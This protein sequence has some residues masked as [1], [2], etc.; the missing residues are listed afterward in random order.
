MFGFIASIGAGLLS[1]VH[2][3]QSKIIR[4]KIDTATT[5]LATAICFAVFSVI[6]LGV[7][8]LFGFRISVSNS[9]YLNAV[10]AAV[11]LTIASL[12]FLKGIKEVPL[13]RALPLLAIGPIIT[14]LLSGAANAT[15]MGGIIAVAI[16][17]FLFRTEPQK[18]GSRLLHRG[19]LYILITGILFGL[20]PIFDARAVAA[21]DPVFYSA[22]GGLLRLLFFALAFVALKQITPKTEGGSVR[23]LI[24]AVALI[25]T[26]QVAEWILQMSALTALSPPVVVAIKEAT[27]VLG[28]L[29]YGKFFRR[30][31]L[32]SWA[33]IGALLASAGIVLI[34]LT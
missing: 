14:L 24:P 32:S 28:A 30:E 23:P 17:M 18:N 5:G 9:F 11:I 15:E 10:L 1:L 21:S 12:S 25:A 26:I 27:I 13:S 20:T 7:F 22:I 6:V 34:R 16:A 29:F 19:Q 2:N 3:D 8:V 4:G 31:K 33:I